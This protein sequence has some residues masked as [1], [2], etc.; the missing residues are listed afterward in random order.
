MD[1]RHQRYT[2]ADLAADAIT[3]AALVFLVVVVLL[4][5]GVI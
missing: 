1:R 5:T 4:H 3:A 2:A